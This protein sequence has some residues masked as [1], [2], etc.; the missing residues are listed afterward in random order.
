MSIAHQLK[1]CGQKSLPQAIQWGDILFK[2]EKVFKHDFFAATALYQRDPNQENAPTERHAS[3]PIPQRLIL[4]W[5]R[6]TDFLGLPLGWLGQWITHHE[7]G[8]L[9]QLQGLEGIPLFIGPYQSHGF[10]Y[11]YIEGVSL[12]SRP[13]IPDDF[14]DQTETILNNIHARNIAYLDLNKKGNILLGQDNKPHIIDFQISWYCDDVFE[15]FQPLFQ[16]LL[17]RLQ[18]EDFYHLYKH[19][20]RFR[21]DLMS[22]TEINDSHQTS[23]LIRLHRRIT[24]PLTLLRRRLLGWLMKKGLL[25]TDD[26]SETHSETDPSRWSKK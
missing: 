26:L 24:R 2:I 5:S 15:H 3:R 22:Q 21:P 1:A 19:K 18:Q 7:Q 12:D 14:F 11:E 17:E 9:K 4:K 6:S 10:L 25:I 20:R 8:V 13:K 16:K 23:L